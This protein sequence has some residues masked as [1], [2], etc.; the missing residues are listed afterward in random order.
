MHGDVEG[1]ES[2]EIDRHAHDR[3]RPCS[4]TSDHV[5]PQRRHDLRTR[6]LRGISGQAPL[7]RLYEQ[8]PNYEVGPDAYAAVHEAIVRKD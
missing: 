8:G 1:G 4:A 6:R 3:S 2:S 5:L 7:W